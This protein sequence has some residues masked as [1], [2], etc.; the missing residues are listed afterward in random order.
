MHLKALTLA[1]PMN[2]LILESKIMKKKE[3]NEP[4]RIG[5]ALKHE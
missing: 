5:G 1:I 3:I 4:N 2:I